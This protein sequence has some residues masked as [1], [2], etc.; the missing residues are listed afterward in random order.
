[1]HL[2]DIEG[3]SKSFYSSNPKFFGQ[4][5]LG[6]HWIQSGSTLFTIPSV[7]FGQISV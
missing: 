4:T 2:E 7:P 3:I 1:M 6:K 5:Y